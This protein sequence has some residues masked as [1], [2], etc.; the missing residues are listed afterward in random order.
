MSKVAVVTGATRGIGRSIALKFASEGYRVYSISRSSGEDEGIT[1]LNAD[2]RDFEAINDAFRKIMKIE[3][4]VDVLVCNAGMGIAGAVEFTSESDIKYQLDVNLLGC[5]YSSKS[6]ISHMREM[7]SGKIFFI[8]SLGGIFPLPFQSFYSVTKAGIN[9]YSDAL[10]IELKP[11]GVQ[12][13]AVLLNDV[14][15]DFTDNRKTFPEGDEAYGGRILRSV[16]KME[17]SE[18]NGISTETVADRVFKLAQRKK[19]SPHYIVGFSN[20]LLC[21][22]MRILPTRTAMRILYKVYGE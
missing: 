13:C 7:R 19:M 2:V 12:T 18:R 4:K 15:S 8:S 5:I 17:V 11:Y 14:K 1:Y 16:R 9:A 6:V 21:F 3:K 22:L 10:G 20:I